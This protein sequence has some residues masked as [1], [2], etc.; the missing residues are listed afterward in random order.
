MLRLAVKMLVGDRTKFIGILIGLTFA[1]FIIT[2]QMGIFIGLMQRT[3]GFITDTSQPN[4]W[5]MDSQV[6]QVDD[7]K[8]IKFTKLFQV[9]GIEEVEW[10]VPLFKGLLRARLQNGVF[11]TCN[12]IGIDDATLIGG[13]PVVTRGSI[14]DLREPNA[15]IVN[16]VGAREKLATPSKG[17]VET[18]IP[19]QL[20]T[21]FE[22]NNIRAEVVGF[23]KTT[24]SF[25]SQPVIYTTFNRAIN[26]A[27]KERNL[28]TFI[29]V[30]SKKGVDPEVLCKQISERTGL[31]A[32]TSR[33]FKRL[34]I[35]YYLFQTGIPINFGVSVGLGFIIGMAIAGQIFYNFAHD[36]RHYFATFKAM[37]ATQNLLTNM[38]LLQALVVASLSW[39]LGVGATALFGFL[40]SKTEISF[41]LPWW[42]LV[43][44]ALSILA[45]TLLA[46]L[47]G[48][49]QITRL[50][51]GIVFQT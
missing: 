25:M 11:Q 44:S 38:I 17:W 45:I 26:Y 29:L 20:G 48:I 22:I 5:V 2:Q 39:G 14:L 35:L 9:R 42:L 31:A 7:I 21:A 40:T 24:R 4:I 3:Y 41:T 30:K 33:G 6:Q 19:L 46:A 51:P 15:V 28:L 32:Y 43:G 8:T 13:P 47:I 12:V 18:R 1:T 27:P 49:R 16:E 10:A 50:E 37:G 23:C 34:T 36:N